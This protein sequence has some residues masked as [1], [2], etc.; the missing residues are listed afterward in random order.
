[1]QGLGRGRVC[2]SGVERLLEG[3]VSAPGF[4]PRGAGSGEGRADQVARG[5]KT[6]TLEPGTYRKRNSNCVNTLER[7]YPEGRGKNLSFQ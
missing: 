2:R 5:W 6:M 3:G 7:R 1:M 4:S